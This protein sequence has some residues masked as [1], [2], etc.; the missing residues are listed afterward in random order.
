MKHLSIRLKLTL[1]YGTAVAVILLG[2][3]AV[4]LILTRQQLLNRT[5]GTLREELREIVLEIGIH[6]SEAEFAQAAEKRFRQH[7]VYD[8]VVTDH[9][10][11]IVF[12][13]AGLPTADLPQI[14][15]EQRAAGAGFRSC[16]LA[17]SGQVR[18]A[19]AEVDSS[20]GRLTVLAVTSLEPLLNEIRTL[21]LVLAILLPVAVVF[22]LLGGSFLAT[23]ALRPVASMAE[24]ASSITID[25][26]NRRVAILNPHD[27]I[28]RLATTLNSLIDRLELAVTEIRRFTADASHELRTPLAALRMEAELALCC[29]RTPQQY[30]DSLR[31][32]VDEATR[33]GRLADQLLKLSREDAGITECHRHSVPLHALLRDIVDQLRQPAIAREVRFDSSGIHPCRVAGDDIRLRQVF[34]NIIENAV[35]F[36]HRGGTVRISSSRDGNSVVCIVSDSGI[37]IPQEQLPHVFRRFYRVDSSRH[38]ETGGA[39]LGLSIARLSVEA[40]RGSIDIHSQE[41][42]GTTVVVSLPAAAVDANGQDEAE[43]ADRADE[44]DDTSKPVQ[45]RNQM[46]VETR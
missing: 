1:W 6:R 18:I 15:S 29:E 16:S 14:L 38:C 25:S 10:G 17:G 22:A 42:S 31:V 45:H 24:V 37:G 8:F 33:L 28:G 43:D 4:L 41:G 13:S 30:Q 44:A 11:R 12:Q 23:R 34:F 2:L 9:N 32:V 39:G 5:D 36:S 7:D 19:G 46:I 35:K 20:F 40:H 21:Q 27:E 3:G 26:L